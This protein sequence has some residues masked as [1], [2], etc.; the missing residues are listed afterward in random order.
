MYVVLE[1][2]LEPADVDVKQVDGAAFFKINPWRQSKTYGEYC[3]VEHTEIISKIA[4]NID[5]LDLAFDIYRTKST[6]SQIRTSW[7][8]SIRVSVRKETSI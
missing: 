8:K 6:K 1:P 4:Q 7:E 5:R 3:D 2:S